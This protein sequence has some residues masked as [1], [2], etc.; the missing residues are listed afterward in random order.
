MKQGK[1][2]ANDCQRDIH[3]AR[4]EEV[5][6]HA[7]DDLCEYFVNNGLLLMRQARCL[8]SWRMGEI[9]VRLVKRVRSD[10][11]EHLRNERRSV[12]SYQLMGDGGKSLG[13]RVT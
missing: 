5:T 10:F 7:L 3:I 1:T 6:L 4:E 11:Q 8:Y 2:S 13:R 12:E 9:L